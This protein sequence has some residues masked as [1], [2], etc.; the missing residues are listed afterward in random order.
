VQTIGSPRTLNDVLIITGQEG[1]R[2]DQNRRREAVVA[3]PKQ[4]RDGGGRGGAQR[5]RP[6]AGGTTRWTDSLPYG[7]E[8]TGCGFL[9]ST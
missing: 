1:G 4:G 8:G 5:D 2:G 9:A 3:P 7:R 6:D